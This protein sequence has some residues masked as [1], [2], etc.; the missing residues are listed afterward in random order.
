M[1]SMSCFMSIYASFQINRI[2]PFFV[3]ELPQ[4]RL[5][6]EGKDK[7]IFKILLTGDVHSITIIHVHLSHKM[8]F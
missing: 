6:V 8:N 1:Y 3:T 5:V 2:K 4:L 7:N